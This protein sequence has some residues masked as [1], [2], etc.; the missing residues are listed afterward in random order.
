MMVLYFYSKIWRLGNRRRKIWGCLRSPGGTTH[1]VSFLYAVE[2]RPCD[3]AMQE[4]D[5]FSRVERMDTCD[6][7]GSTTWFPHTQLA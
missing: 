1:P 5:L 2:E 7:I 3:D 6:D 4:W